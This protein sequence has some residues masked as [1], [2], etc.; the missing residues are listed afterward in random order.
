[1]TFNLSERVVF[2]PDE[3]PDY[4]WQYNQND[5]KE[6]IKLLKEGYRGLGYFKFCE[7]IDKLAGDK[8]I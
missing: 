5:V 3:D 2:E 4:R 6:F 7:L 8:L 1:M